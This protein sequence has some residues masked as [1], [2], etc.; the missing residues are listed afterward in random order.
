MYA[1]A[2]PSQFDTVVG[3]LLRHLSAVATRM[4][5]VPLGG[6]A[7]ARYQG[8]TRVVLDASNGNYGSHVCC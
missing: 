1:E 8:A 5:T 4:Q 2:E 7:A 6:W 3:V